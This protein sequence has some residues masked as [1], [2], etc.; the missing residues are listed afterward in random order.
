MSNPVTLIPA[1]G[2]AIRAV[3][4]Q[5]IQ[6]LVALCSEHADF[7]R[8]AYDPAGKALLL[9]QALFAGVP[10]LHAWVAVSDGRLAGYA[11]AT[12]EYSTWSAAE[13]LHMDCLFVQSER[14]GMGI[15]AALMASVLQLARERGYAEVQ[16]QTPSWNID[17]CRFYRRH[18]GVDQE[19]LRF[20]LTVRDL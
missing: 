18:G 15:G 14:R 9:S 10:R 19:K 16:W 17:A 4:P 3:L 1:P 12:A 2:C 20:V 8:A 11:T 5:D 13:Y 6:G 7:E